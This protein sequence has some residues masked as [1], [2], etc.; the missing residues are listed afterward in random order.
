MININS[1][2]IKEAGLIPII[3][4][5]SFSAILI[6]FSWGTAVSYW[7]EYSMLFSIPFIMQIFNNLDKRKSKISLIIILLWT[8]L[9]IYYDIRALINNNQNSYSLRQYFTSQNKKQNSNGYLSSNEYD[10]L[11]YLRNNLNSQDIV[12]SDR[13]EIFDYEANEIENRFFFYSA[14]S[15]KQMYLEGSDYNFINKKAGIAERKKIVKT[16]YS[17]RNQDT[18]S[19]ICSRN[20]ISYIIWSKRIK[21]KP[22]L[23]EVLNP[24]FENNDIA[25]Y[26][27]K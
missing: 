20:R 2:Y 18:I 3:L 15:G 17:S 6:S 8:I 23:S 10:G 22:A 13:T 11:Q 25:I 16:I 26:K 27:V 5:L 21:N 4:F 7:R 19:N 1:K 12:L 14:F 24:V 9:S